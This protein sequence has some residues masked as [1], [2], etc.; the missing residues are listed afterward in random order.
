MFSDGKGAEAAAVLSVTKLSCT[1]FVQCTCKRF[2]K[3]L[4]NV[5]LQAVLGPS[6][7][8]SPTIASWCSQPAGPTGRTADARAARDDTCQG[9]MRCSRSSHCALVP[10]DLPTALMRTCVTVPSCDASGHRTPSGQ[11][12]LL[13]TFKSQQVAYTNASNQHSHCITP[14]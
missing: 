14:P 9:N 13:Q 4:V 8:R 3:L 7:L 12:G 10:Y 1:K 6:S 2:L 11:S 5:Q